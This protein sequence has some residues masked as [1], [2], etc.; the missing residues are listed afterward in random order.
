VDVGERDWVKG[1]ENGEFKAW[2]CMHASM[3]ERGKD[4]MDKLEDRGFP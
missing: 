1:I 4:D 2:I 3:R